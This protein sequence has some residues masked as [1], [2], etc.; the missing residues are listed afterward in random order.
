[1]AKYVIGIIVTIALVLYLKLKDFIDAKI[2][3]IRIKTVDT[4]TS[5]IVYGIK[6]ICSAIST[7]FDPVAQK[8]KE[9][10]SDGKLTEEDIKMLQD[11]TRAAALNIIKSL[12]QSNILE[13]LGVSEENIKALISA[14]IE[15]SV[16]RRKS[17]E[18]Y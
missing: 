6:E 13:G 7:S 15:A 1:M 17:G 3:E 10:S 12:Y 11:E 14:E 8:L 5:K 18:M 16:Q 9:A 4:K 2:E